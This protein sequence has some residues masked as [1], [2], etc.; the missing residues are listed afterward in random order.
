MKTSSNIDK[1]DWLKNW[2]PSSDNHNNPNKTI[3]KLYK[4]AY[5]INNKQARISLPVKID[6]FLES[7][8]Y[9]LPYR[10]ILQTT[11]D[12]SK[13]NLVIVL[14]LDT[15]HN[16]RVLDDLLDYLKG[17]GVDTDFLYSTVSVWTKNAGSHI[18][19]QHQVYSHYIDNYGEENVR[20]AIKLNKKI[21]IEGLELKTLDITGVG[22]YLS[23]LDG[24]N[25][26]YVFDGPENTPTLMPIEAH[27]HLLNSY[28]YDLE[29]KF[30]NVNES[31]NPAITVEL[32]ENLTNMFFV[33][34]FINQAKK[35]VADS[36]DYNRFIGTYLNLCCLS[37]IYGTKEFEELGS[38]NYI[39]VEHSIRGFYNK[40]RDMIWKD[41]I[42]YDTIPDFEPLTPEQEEVALE[43]LSDSYDYWV[44]N[45][46]KKV[47]R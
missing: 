1:R 2:C 22:S 30:G 16:P 42:Y 20:K 12:Q 38:L 15:K 24:V 47:K 23:N 27:A 17:V 43:Y 36:Q 33:Q 46:K 29:R 32:K 3:K 25:T 41:S 7:Y 11:R 21:N 40:V 8:E 4:E 39:S 13:D 18:Y 28:M 31:R 34:F 14:D 10:G 35:N 45:Q 26:P 6:S 44:S 37:T 9:G 19:L 5:Y